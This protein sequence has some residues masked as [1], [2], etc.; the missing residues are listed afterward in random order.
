VL[1][2]PLLAVMAMI[3]FEQDPDRSLPRYR[4][5]L[6]ERY[7]DRVLTTSVR[8]PEWLAAMAKIADVTGESTH[9]LQRPSTLEAF[10]QHLAAVQV[11]S[12]APLTAAAHQWLRRNSPVSTRYPPEWDAMVETI[13]TRNGM[14]L[15]QG[16]RWEFVHH[17]FA[18]HLAAAGEARNLPSPFQPDDPEWRGCIERAVDVFTGTVARIA[19]VHWSRQAP[20]AGTRLLD[21]LQGCG[22]RYQQLAATLLTT[23]VPGSAVHLD[24]ATEVVERRVLLVY[25]GQPDWLLASI[26]R[27]HPPAIDALTRIA[28]NLMIPTW[29]RSAARARVIAFRELAPEEA[30]QSLRPLLEEP[31]TDAGWSHVVAAAELLELGPQH[32]TAAIDILRGVLADPYAHPDASKEAAIALGT[33]D[34]ELRPEAIAAL[35]SIIA[36]PLADTRE[37]SFATRGLS[38]LGLPAEAAA[39]LDA[40]LGDPQAE[41]YDKIWISYSYERLPTQY[42]ATAIATFQ[43]I[44]D[45]ATDLRMRHDAAAAL[46]RL[47]P[48]QQPHAIEVFSQILA[49]PS[50]DP[51]LRVEAAEAIG[52][53]APDRRD[54]ATDELRTILRDTQVDPETRLDA[55][56]AMVRL[57]YELYHEVVTTLRQAAQPGANPD[58]RL[59]AA[60][61]LA[62]LGPALQPEAFDG[63]RAVAALSTAA[64]S[65]RIAAAGLLG[66]VSTGLRDEATA[67]LREL[68][69]APDRTSMDV[70]E[71]AGYLVRLSHTSDAEAADWLLQIIAD[72]TTDP[73]VRAQ[74]ADQLVQLQTA[75]FTDG[76]DTLRSILNDPETDSD[77]RRWAAQ[78]LAK[79]GSQYRAEALAAA[80]Q[81]NPGP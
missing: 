35:R 41:I 76:V 64:L 68:V 65:T 12:D 14:L 33:A 72:T 81:T 20:D 62:Q 16:S 75:H 28:N 79:C 9:S 51:V 2:V 71:A 31:R 46:A 32:R 50:C 47:A 11:N 24:V 25:E 36:D 6:Y 21:W 69:T 77:L 67:L 18:E 38:A 27:R 13:L 70:V 48:N 37:R 56:N 45:D 54:T 73:W 57:D 1:S 26:A 29:A 40:I 23:G 15:R 43:S 60:H 17:S 7:V 19:L 58:Q 78:R 55:A 22:W 10:L 49:D 39:V 52:S 3:L 8:Q 61:G 53:L 5:D 4:Y 80:S 42:R 59:A 74:A 30:A 66:E 63:L 34:P 44:A